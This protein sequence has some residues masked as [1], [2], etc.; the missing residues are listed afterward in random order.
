MLRICPALV[1]GIIVAALCAPIHALQA[2]EPSTGMG[3]AEEQVTI[4]VHAPAAPFPHYWSRCSAQG[5]PISRC[6][7]A[8]ATI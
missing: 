3:A 5:V 2:S 7:R 6:V 4:D 1:S 8:T